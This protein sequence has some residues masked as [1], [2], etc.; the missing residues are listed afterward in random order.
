MFNLDKEG[1][2]ELVEKVYNETYFEG[3]RFSIIEKWKYYAEISSEDKSRK[4]GIFSSKQDVTSFGNFF[5]TDIQ[6]EILHY[7]A[8]RIKRND[9]IINYWFVTKELHKKIQEY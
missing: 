1:A 5:G 4:Y 8:F 2:I 7:D 6:N 9:K 3:D